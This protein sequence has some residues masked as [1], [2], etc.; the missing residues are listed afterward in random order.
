MFQWDLVCGKQN[1][2]EYAVTVQNFGM[3]LGMLICGPL[4]DRFGRRLVLF[5]SLFM[6]GTFSMTM[7]FVPNFI[8]YCILNGGRGIA[9]SV[10]YV[11]S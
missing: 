7:A 4:V 6:L 11:V 2:V 8:S 1:Y 5:C 9:I 3:I 10:S